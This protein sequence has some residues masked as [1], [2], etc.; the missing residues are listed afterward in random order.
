MRGNEALFLKNGKGELELS[1]SAVAKFA[2]M[3]GAILRRRRRRR[4]RTYNR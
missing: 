4:R 1:D 3:S 2:L